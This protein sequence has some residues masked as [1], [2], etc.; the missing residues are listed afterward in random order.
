ML[1]PA[2]APLG[3][4]GLILAAERSIAL[5]RGF[6]PRPKA[7]S[8]EEVDELIRDALSLHEERMENVV[9]EALGKTR[10]EIEDTVWRARGGSR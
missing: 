8:R 9:V 3:L 4:G 10:R 1:D 6:K 2:T 5:W 7:L